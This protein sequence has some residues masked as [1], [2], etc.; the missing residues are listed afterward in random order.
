MTHQRPN[1]VQLAA[2]QCAQQACES[3]IEQ[4]ESALTL[5]PGN[6]ELSHQLGICYSGS[7]RL[8]RLVSLPLAIE[9]LKHA[10]SL[11]GHHAPQGVRARYLD[12]LGNALR[13]QHQFGEA[14]S[15][16]TEAGSLYKQLNAVDDW[17]RTEFNLGNVCCDLAEAGQCPMW[18]EAVQHFLVSLHVR[19]EESDPLRFAATMQNL[20]TAYRHLVD[21]SPKNAAN[22]LRCYRTALRIYRRNGRSDKC[23]DVHNNLANAYLTLPEPQPSSCRNVRRALRHYLLALEVRTRT[24]KPHDYAVTQFN[25]GQAYLRLA[26]CDPAS[27][28]QA[29]VCFQEAFDAFVASG[30]LDGAGHVRKQAHSLSATPD[31]ELSSR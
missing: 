21:N 23:A 10:V 20:G 28:R 7:C 3:A 11:V 2:K 5:Q 25:C 19:T 18:N 17:A 22:V 6:A 1:P 9:Y 13:S 26:R 27:T 12:S 14:L 31:A 24:D 8:H 4:L 29:A 30:D 16:L 15:P